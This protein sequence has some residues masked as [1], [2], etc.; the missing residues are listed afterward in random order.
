[1]TSGGPSS[2]SNEQFVNEVAHVLLS[3]LSVGSALGPLY[4]VD[5]RLRPHG[6]SGPLVQTLSAS[7]TTTGKRT[8]P[9]SG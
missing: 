6:A 2:I 1:M 4:S 9:G 3:A 7:S 5:A 8:R